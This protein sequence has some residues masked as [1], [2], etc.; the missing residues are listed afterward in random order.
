LEWNAKGI[1]SVGHQ[2]ARDAKKKKEE[3]IQLVL[4]AATESLSLDDWNIVA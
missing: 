1:C 3:H 4:N 2:Q